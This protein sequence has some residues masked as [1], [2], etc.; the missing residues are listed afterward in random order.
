MMTVLAKQYDSWFVKAPAYTFAASV[1]MQRINDNKHWSSDI[2]LGA[3]I[4]YLVGSSVVKRY[5]YKSGYID[6][7]PIINTNGI[8]LNIQF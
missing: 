3:T 2:L 8:G 7:Q 4:G 1:A 5:H 6:L